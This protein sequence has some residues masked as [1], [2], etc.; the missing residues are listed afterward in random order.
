VSEEPGRLRRAVDRL[1]DAQ[2]EALDTTGRVLDAE[3]GEWDEDERP[4]ANERLEAALV[5]VRD[6][7]GGALEDARDILEGGA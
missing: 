3:A 7:L 4:G 2:W 6:I 5:E 1:M